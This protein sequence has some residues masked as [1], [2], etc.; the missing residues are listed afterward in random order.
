MRTSEVWGEGLVGEVGT[1]SSK[2]F[3][4]F[5][6]SEEIKDAVDRVENMELQLEE[7]KE[8][9]DKV[10]SDVSNQLKPELQKLASESKSF[11]METARENSKFMIFLG[12]KR[13]WDLLRW[14]LA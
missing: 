11:D 2:P 4:Y 1:S 8:S 13:R 9:A 12:L 7:V 3:S 6:V 5:T 14:L 10:K